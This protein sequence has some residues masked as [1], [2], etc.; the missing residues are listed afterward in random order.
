MT[1]GTSVL[2]DINFMQNNMPKGLR[3]FQKG[4]KVRLGMKNSSAHTAALRKAAL[5]NQHWLGKKHSEKS[6]RLIGDAHRGKIVSVET[7]KKISG[8]NNSQWRGGISPVRKR[9]YFS[10]QYQEW[11]QLVFERDDHTCVFCGHRNA[12]GKR[13]EINADHII[14]MSLILEKL[15]F[16]QG[17]SDLY[18]KAIKYQE[19]W[20]INNGRTLCIDC[21]K[22]TDTYGKKI[23]KYLI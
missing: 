17:S 23:K 3:G 19:L 13:N 12:T 22:R 7:R 20:D 21:H 14:P 6:K 11:R 9:L 8:E 16:E 2:R 18:N 1:V 15:K 4:N 5:G 10:L